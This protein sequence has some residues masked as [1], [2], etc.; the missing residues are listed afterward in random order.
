[1]HTAMTTPMATSLISADIQ[2]DWSPPCTLRV[3][4]LDLQ[5]RLKTANRA[6]RVLREMGYRILWQQFS[7]T[8]CPAPKIKIERTAQQSLSPLLSRA[9]GHSWRKEGERLQGFTEFMNVT[10]TWDEA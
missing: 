10:I 1:M 5:Q 6:A 4:T 2:E 8:R 3:L 9:K 7:P